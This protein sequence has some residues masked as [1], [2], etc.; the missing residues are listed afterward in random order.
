MLPNDKMLDLSKFEAFAG[1]KI[2]E[3]QK[4]RFVLGR[5]ENIVRK[6][7]ISFYQHFLLCFVNVCKAFFLRIFKNWDCV[8]KVETISV[9]Q[10]F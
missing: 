6:E 3:A 7:G 1:N 8:V 2:N 5:A 10:P 9:L 4:L